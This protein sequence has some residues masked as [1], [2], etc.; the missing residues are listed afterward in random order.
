MSKSTVCVVGKD[1]RL[2]YLASYLQEHGIKVHRQEEFDSTKLCDS[3]YL[4]GPVNFYP[5]GKISAEIAE[6]LSETEISIINY[7]ACEDFLLK[8]AELTAEGLL[9]IIIKNTSFVLAEA[10]ILIL[11]NGRCGRAIFEMLNLFPC[12]LDIYD[13]VP[14]SP[15][16]TPYNIVINTIPAPVLTKELLTQFE[17]DCTFFEIAS[18]PGGFDKAAIEELNLNLIGCP[19]IPGK[20]SPRSAGEAIGRMVMN[21]FSHDT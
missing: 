8:N 4:V 20:Y 16:E 6:S 10:R 18:P 7:M 12:Q 17:P 13:T 3:D 11:G 5:D 21:S 14:V 9:A 15:F 2:E 1:K 19:G